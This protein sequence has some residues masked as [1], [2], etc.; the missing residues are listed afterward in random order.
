M[1]SER[2]K[3]MISI[4]IITLM[5]TLSKAALVPTGGESIKTPPKVI[6]SAR[7]TEP[8]IHEEMVIDL[9]YGPLHME[10]G[11]EGL[12]LSIDGLE[13]D[14]RPD[15]L[16][17]PWETFNLD[18]PVGTI[19]D[20]ITLRTVNMDVLPFNAPI[21]VNPTAIPND[22]TSGPLPASEPLPPPE[23]N[24]EW[25]IGTGIDLDTYE[26]AAKMSIKLHPLLPVGDDLHLIR[27]GSIHV[28][29]SYPEPLS[30][31]RAEEYDMLII[32]PEA[33]A[34]GL[35]DYRDYRN[36]TGTT[37]KLVT[38]EEILTDVQWDIQE[39]DTQEE[40]KRL[41]YLARLNWGVDFVML[42]GDQ[43]RIPARHVMVLDGYDDTYTSGSQDGRFVP[44]D[45]YYSDLF[46]GGGTDF[47]GWNDFRT[48]DSELLWGEST[49][50]YPNRDGM[51]FYPDVLLGRITPS[52][53]G[54]LDT[55]LTKIIEYELNAR[56]SVW[57]NNATLC[58]TD[59]FLQYQYPEGE[60]VSDL[61]ANNYLTSFNVTK[62]YESLGN[63]TSIAST[64]NKGCGFFEMADH[65]SYTGW[66]FTGATPSGAVRSTTVSSLDNY[67]MLPVVVLDACLTS[68]FDNENASSTTDGKDPV[69][70]YW[71]YPP[72]ISSS[73]RDSLAEK[74]HLNPDGGGIATYGATRVGW[75]IS[76][77]GHPTSLSGYMNTRFFKAYSDGKTRAGELI[78]QA[79]IDYRNNLGI[80]G[81]HD[82]KT[83][84]EYVLLGDPSLNIGG[85]NST[86]VRIELDANEVSGLPGENITVGLALN[87]TGFLGA[88]F[89]LNIFS[90]NLTGLSWKAEFTP[91]S[92]N[93]LPGT[94]GSGSLRI[95]VPEMALNTTHEIFTLSVSSNFLREERSVSLRVNIERIWG[96]GSFPKIEH[97]V[98]GPNSSIWGSAELS[99]LGNGD[100]I[101]N[102]TMIDVPEGW[103]F[104]FGDDRMFNLEDLTPY[105]KASVTYLLDVPLEAVAGNYSIGLTSTSTVTPASTT[106]RFS[107]LVEIVEGLILEVESTDIQI[108]PEETRVVDV[109][110]INKGNSEMSYYLDLDVSGVVGWPI[111]FGGNTIS[112]LPFSRSVIPL[113]ITGPDGTLADRYGLTFTAA[114]GNLSQEVDLLIEVTARHRFTAY[115]TVEV[116]S[117]NGTNSA[118]LTINVM[119]QGNKLDRY[120]ITR[121]EDGTSPWSSNIARP[122]VT[123][124]PL[125]IGLIRV[126]IFYLEPLNGSY[127]ISYSI[128]PESGGSPQVVTFLVLVEKVF[129]F[130]VTGE[131][132][133]SS[134]EPGEVIQVSYR[135]RNL[136]NCQDVFTP[137]F[138]VPWD[139]EVYPPPADINMGPGEEQF[140]KV[141]FTTPESG[142]AGIYSLNA[143]FTSL[144]LDSSLSV[145]S[146]ASIISMYSIGWVLEGDVG[147]ISVGP[148]QTDSLL[149]TITNHGN[150]Y[151]RFEIHIIGH[152]NLTRW[153]S[154]SDNNVRL[155]PGETYNI[156]LSISIPSNATNL[157]YPVIL[158]L[159]YGQGGSSNLTFNLHL[160][161]PELEERLAKE[162]ARNISIAVIIGVIILVLMI[163]GFIFVWRRGSGVDVE[164]AGM[165]WD[166][167]EDDWADED[168]DEL[169][170]YE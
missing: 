5:L 165:E 107:V 65:G 164:E 23:T 51:D 70:G 142:L 144:G 24:M 140:L 4:T 119:N 141:N 129:N 147:S 114:G 138:S 41:I 108:A 78:A 82:V 26:T 148:G 135:I 161:D 84:T 15:A 39:N 87:N 102:M 139:W 21:R 145:E 95:R 169:D 76:G 80:S 104:S 9:E 163:S 130:T 44:S 38:L 122:T 117:I 43:D 136:A 93:L 77:Y 53:T 110:V 153:L 20:D 62:H 118:E 146:S 106:F 151:D 166:D 97:V 79:E 47:C 156:T 22:Y 113:T 58:G 154:F 33:F 18:L 25:E 73:A 2:K 63:L 123:V 7:L 29:Y 17:L 100:E 40:I 28:S 132:Q 99:N 64:V 57:F 101:I 11:P 74:F 1:G 115:P 90:E 89:E 6:E 14:P 91:E 54:E 134:V 170:E 155:A 128:A 158:L 8:L 68:G 45:L 150:D 127:S 35:K 42:A 37:N 88:L 71:Y 162:E 121:V 98:C 13:N 61:I 157:E 83:V 137:Y 48:G 160:V 69:Y 168:Y 112:I 32:A 167:D 94:S 125:E 109:T 124:N 131:M 36:S 46:E 52:T 30:A 86:N 126:D 92:M 96:L 27:S 111:S 103:N 55:M 116:I 81:T 59:T 105:G 149:I 72:G 67:Y 159:G 133:I 85:I 34:D 143:F 19:I 3:A 49:S 66:G 75:G 12:E 16:S 10:Q 60:I 120:D 31:T 50:T 56:D 152:Y